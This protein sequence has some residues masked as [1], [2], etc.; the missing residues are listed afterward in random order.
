MSS[1]SLYDVEII[2]GVPT[3]VH[4]DSRKPWVAEAPAAA[5]AGREKTRL[6]AE[7]GARVE[8]PASSNKLGQTFAPHENPTF[9]A[10]RAAVFD[11]VIAAQRQRIAAKPRVPINITLPDG[12]V[13][14][15]TS[16]ETTPMSIAES[17]S[18]G[19]AASVVVAR[20]AHT[21]RVGAE[22]ADGGGIVNT[23]PEEEDAGAAAGSAAV[24]SELWD[25]VRPLEGDCSLALLK[26]DDKDG[27]M[28]FWHSSAHVLGECLECKYGAQLCIGPPT[29]DGFYYDAYLGGK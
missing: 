27:K 26:F 20:V 1:S 14:Q 10:E 24:Q 7:S 16:W 3:V 11:E 15:G 4:R 17:I 9:L 23:G 29:E 21:S 12:K 18:K 5:A 6:T 13:V 28:V 22:A 25:L 19:L 2:G 8:G